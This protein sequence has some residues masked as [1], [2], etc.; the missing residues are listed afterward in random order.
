MLKAICNDNKLENPFSTYMIQVM[1]LVS[2]K[3]LYDNTLNGIESSTFALDSL[4]TTDKSL[5]NN[6]KFKTGVIRDDIID[7]MLNMV[8]SMLI[9]FIN[10][11]YISGVKQETERR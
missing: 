9:Y 3:E 4:N 6:A 11:K 7:I 8:S 5:K 2:S 10:L 1:A